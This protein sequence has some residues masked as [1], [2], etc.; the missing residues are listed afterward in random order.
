MSFFVEKIEKK[1]GCKTKHLWK[2]AFYPQGKD[3]LKNLVTQR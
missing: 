1:I 3:C 2:K